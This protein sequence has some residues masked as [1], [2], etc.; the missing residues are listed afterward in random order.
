MEEK[1]VPER[2]MTKEKNMQTEEVTAVRWLFVNADQLINYQK[3]PLKLAQT[4]SRNGRIVKT[5]NTSRSFE[6]IK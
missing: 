6:H 3:I 1:I 2:V 4:T 5:H